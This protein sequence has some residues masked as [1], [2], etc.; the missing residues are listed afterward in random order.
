MIA[1]SISIF[2]SSRLVRCRDT[3]LQTLSDSQ[4]L[5]AKPAVSLLDW[6]IFCDSYII[7]RINYFVNRS[8]YYKQQCTH[9][10]RC[11][12]HC[13]VTLVLSEEKGHR[14]SPG[15]PPCASSPSMSGWLHWRAVFF[16]ANAFPAFYPLRR[17]FDW[18]STIWR[19]YSYTAKNLSTPLHTTY[20]FFAAFFR[21]CRVGCLSCCLSLATLFLIYR[22]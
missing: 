14:T 2:S 21:L 15:T 20:R 17:P 12:G 11:V 8:V 16:S 5:S 6:Y 4:S 10:T 9:T 3:P 19:T 18:I 22:F 13:S 1:P 7:F